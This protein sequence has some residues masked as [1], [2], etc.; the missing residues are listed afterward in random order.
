M[1]SQPELLLS[2]LKN[3]CT[4]TKGYDAHV[5]RK[6]V[7]LWNRLT[8]HST[9]SFDD[10]TTDGGHSTVS[11]LMG[12][13][14]KQERGSHVLQDYQMQLMQLEQQ[15]QKWLLIAIRSVNFIEQQAEKGKMWSFPRQAS[16]NGSFCSVL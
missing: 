2:R 13:S 1:V 6:S 9:S 7:T 11:R 3:A 5:V 16:S 12:N 14:L 8:D 4:W 10:L 15:S